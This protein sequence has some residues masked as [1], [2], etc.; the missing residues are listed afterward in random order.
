MKHTPRAVAS[1][2]SCSLPD[3][4]HKRSAIIG[5]AFL[6]ATSAVGPG[7]LTQTT[8]FTAKFGV[9]FGVVIAASLAL[10]I[11]V[12][13]VVWRLIVVSGLTANDIAD[14]VLPGSGAALALAVCAGG[15]LFNCGNLAGAGLGI[16]SL[17]GGN[18]D[19][20]AGAPVQWGAAASALIAASLFLRRRFGGALDAFAQAMGGFMIAGMAFALASSEAPFG[21]LLRQALSPGRFD[22]AAT[23]TLVGGTV[24]G[25]ITFAG[26]HRLLDAGFKGAGA[27]GAASLSALAGIS[28]AGILRILAFLAALGAL[29]TGASLDA[30]NPAAL[31]FRHALGE[32]GERVFGFVLWA[33]SMT[34]VVGATY[35]SL[36]FARAYLSPARRFPRASAFAFIAAS[37][38]AF[39]IWGKPV[40]ALVFAGLANSFVLPFSLALLLRAAFLPEIVGAYRLPPF[41]ALAAALAATGLL[42]M[43]ALALFSP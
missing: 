43:S 24:G 13:L 3:A 6:M 5:A 1:T 23:L 34:S 18:F 15:L 27:L 25:Y 42:A 21:E 28:F 39:W 14:R 7:F 38:G 32:T 9:D 31:A 41:L 30:E 40:G 35:A 10:D 33:A 36:T 22:S 29:A 4:S 20:A 8:V 16:K 26:G 37:L 17:T 11:I 2:P 12:Q 19:F